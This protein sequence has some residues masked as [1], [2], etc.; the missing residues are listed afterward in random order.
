MIVWPLYIIC[1]EIVKGRSKNAIV[2]QIFLG[3]NSLPLISKF[4]KSH[5]N[6]SMLLIAG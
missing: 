1:T 3:S 2:V 5:L 4:V 6:A